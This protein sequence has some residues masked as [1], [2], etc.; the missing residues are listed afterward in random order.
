[1]SI[2][3]DPGFAKF[4]RLKPLDSAHV[5]DLLSMIP[6]IQNP[7]DRVAGFRVLQL[8]PGVGP[9][10]AGR[11]LEALALSPDAVFA[12][13]TMEP[14]AR[15]AA[16]WPSLVTALT[17]RAAWPASLGMARAWFD[18]HLDRLHEDATATGMS[19]PCGPGSSTKPCWRIST[20]SAGP[21]RN[22]TA[23]RPHPGRI[24]VA[25]GT[26]GALGVGLG[27]AEGCNE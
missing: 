9:K 13:E 24:D 22:G 1:M 8:L 20:A 7:R 25:P 26:A 2:S 11:V 14:L 4:G 19:T 23:R 3:L 21:R 12:L 18:P 6:F 16:D 5:K 10:A 17:S 15:S 27:A